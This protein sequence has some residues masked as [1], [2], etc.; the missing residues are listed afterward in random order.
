MRARLRGRVLEL[1]P[2]P[3]GVVMS[4]TRSW[5]HKAFEDSLRLDGLQKA[6]WVQSLSFA[7]ALT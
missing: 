4:G 7:V 6:N 5:L 2:S 3:H 1:L